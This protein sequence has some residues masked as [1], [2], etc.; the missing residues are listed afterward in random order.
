MAYCYW[1]G[2]TATTT[3]VRLLAQDLHENG[4]TVA[5]PLLPGHGTVPDDLNQV[6]WEDWAWEAEKSLQHLLTVCDHVFVGGESMGG[7]LTLYMAIRF[8]EIAGI[9]CYAPA[10]KLNMP[11]LKEAQLHAVAPFKESIPKAAD[12]DNPN[13]FWQGYAVNPLKAVEELV[14]MGRYVRKNLDKIE[15]PVL[16]VQGRQ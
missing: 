12:D 5:G 11:L 14:E 4:F 8:P 13:P 6:K 3:E 9:M 10:I 2:L 7:A 15:Q 16:V 1:H